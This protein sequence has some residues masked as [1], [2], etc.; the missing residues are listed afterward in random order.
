MEGWWRELAD[1]RAEPPL[2]PGAGLG[3]GWAG[4][5]LPMPR[6]G[7][8]GVSWAC[9]PG[10]P[11]VGGVPV[12]SRVKLPPHQ[13]LPTTWRKLLEGGGSP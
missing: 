6:P 3:G 10:Q 8:A 11:W 13:P 9:G 5:T 4:W 1:L 2:G 7:G 12:G